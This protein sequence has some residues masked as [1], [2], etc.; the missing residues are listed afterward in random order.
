M[1]DRP[2]LKLLS[3]SPGAVEARNPRLA[4]LFAYWSEKCAGRTMPSRADI[5]PLEMR[6]WLGNL[7]L[8]EF[9][10][11]IER[12][13]VRIDGTNLID[14]GGSDRTGKG[15]ETLTSQEERRIVG[16]Q[17]QAVLDTAQPAYFETQFTNSQRRFL[18]EQKLLL[19][20]SDDSTR[21]NMVLAGIYYQDI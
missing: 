3:P 8:V 1:A 15:A 7:L 21:V 10:G 20:L 14:Y 5:D 6:E 9:L 12:Y 2:D 13:R 11:G 19:P 16:A 4:R 17:Y 18:R